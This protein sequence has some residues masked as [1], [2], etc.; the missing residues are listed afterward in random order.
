MALRSIYAA[1]QPLRTG[2]QRELTVRSVDS[3]PDTVW[4]APE[5]SH[6]ASIE[7]DFPHPVT[8]DRTLTMEWL[9]DGQKVR[10]TPSR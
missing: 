1:T 10:S 4:S 6:S 7:L 5:G 3:D 8:F 2:R 9:L